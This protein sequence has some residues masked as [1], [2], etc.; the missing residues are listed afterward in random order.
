MWLPRL[1][2]LP[3][4]L[5]SLRSGLVGLS[6]AGPKSRELLARISGEDVSNAAFPFMQYRQM[7]LG[8]IPAR[9]GR[10]TF[11]GDLGYEIWVTPDYHVSLL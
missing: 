1:G 10:L 8:M 9:V 4:S 6:I 5:R 2:C 3:K 7:D 11:T